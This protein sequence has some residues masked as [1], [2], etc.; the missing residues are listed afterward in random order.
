[1]KYYISLSGSDSNPGTADSPFRTIQR[2]ADCAGPGDVIIVHEGIYREKV[3]PPRGGESDDKRIT[4]KV[5]PGETVSIKGSEVIKDWI[6]QNGG[7]WMVTLPNDYFGSFNPYA[8]ILSG[9]WMFPQGMIHHT[10]AV[11]VNN[12]A[13]NEAATLEELFDS[14]SRKWFGKSNDECTHIWANFGRLNPN[15]E[16][17]EINVR[18]SVFYPSRPGINYITVIG[19]ILSQAATP[20]SP[21]TT[22][23][24]GLI[25]TNWSKGWIIEQN[26][27]THSRCSGITLGKYF[28]REDGLIEYGFNAHYQ[29]VQKLLNRGDWTKEKVGGHIIRNNQIAFCEQAGIVGSHGAAFCEI[30]DNHIHHIHTKRQFGGFEQAGIKLHAAVDT[31]IRHNLIHDCWMGIWL[32]WMDQGAR[33]SKNILFN[34]D[35]WG[36]LFLEISH[37]P[38]MVDNNVMMSKRS[39]YDSAQGNAYVHNLF[40]GEIEQREEKQRSTPYFLPHST[41]WAGDSKVFD[42]DE[43]FY[44]NIIV[45]DRGLAPYD[46]TKEEVVIEGNIYLFKARPSKLDLKARSFPNADTRFRIVLQGKEVFLDMPFDIEWKL[47]SPDR[48]VNTAILGKTS[49]S[50]QRFENPDGSALTVDSDFLNQPRD[51]RF[52]FPGPFELHESTERIV[53]W[54][55]QTGAMT[56][57]NVIEAGEIHEAEAR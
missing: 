42:G 31:T 45:G 35:N 38:V 34:N 21:P 20:W 8:N 55:A 25:G 10:G 53:L 19:F 26:T 29:T 11:Y 40:G 32:D 13:L 50:N 37:G 44:N 12:R 24:I 4:F 14:L 17:T 5:A 47:K 57:E 54:S 30:Y 2:G 9:D 18:Q 15:E 6:H 51:A 48:L 33:I 16:N 1:M 23:Q 49:V 43:R 52:P 27:V 28:D 3:D 22:E 41:D 7:V 56:D 39:L 36:D 46:D